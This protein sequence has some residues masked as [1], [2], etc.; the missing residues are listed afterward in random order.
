MP[1]VFIN[2]MD[3]D[4]ADKR[5]AVFNK[6]LY[7]PL[8]LKK[9]KWNPINDTCTI[10][11]EKFDSNGNEPDTRLTCFGSNQCNHTFHKQCLQPWLVNN[12]RCPI[13]RDSGGVVGKLE[14]RKKRDIF[15]VSNLE[16]NNR[17]IPHMMVLD[18]FFSEN[19]ANLKINSIKFMEQKGSIE[20]RPFGWK[21]HN[22]HIDVCDKKNCT[23]KSC[24]HMIVSPS[25]FIEWYYGI[26]KKLRHPSFTLKNMV[27]H[28]LMPALRTHAPHVHEHLYEIASKD[29]NLRRYD[30]SV[31]R[32]AQT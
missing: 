30:Y 8:P 15:V 3:N 4:L 9:R 21:K 6:L 19:L 2:C 13:C 23:S 10:C 18:A 7:K 14:R 31:I 1:R 29:H 25:E 32:A 24:Q 17:E 5:R 22:L 12:R 26:P 11:L 16:E 20:V 28:V 27:K